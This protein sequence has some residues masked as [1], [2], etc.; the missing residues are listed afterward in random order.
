M[1]DAV[2]QFLSSKKGLVLLTNGLV[3]AGNAIAGFF[4][5]EVDHVLVGSFVAASMAWLVSQGIQ[6]HGE[7]AAAINAESIKGLDTLPPDRAL[8]VTG[9]VHS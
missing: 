1:K 6:D 3:I 9:E 7:S 4:G 8:V 5:Y 2:L